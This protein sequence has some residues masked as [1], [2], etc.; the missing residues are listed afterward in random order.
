MATR[1]PRPCNGRKCRRHGSMP[2]SLEPVNLG[3]ESCRPQLIRS[4]P[5][6][7]NSFGIV[8]E[9]GGLADPMIRVMNTTKVDENARVSSPLQGQVLRH[10]GRREVAL[11]L[12]DD[13]L[14]VA[15]FVDGQ[16]ELIDAVAWIRFNC[17]AAT[18]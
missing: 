11:F 12:R 3:A 14:G 5:H 7:G 4:W 6:K 17:G 13:A 18:S 9:Y 16:G 10:S 15:D 2:A 8:L 1:H